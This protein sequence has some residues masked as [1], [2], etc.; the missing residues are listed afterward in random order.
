[1][2]KEF[3]L[4]RRGRFWLAYFLL[5]AFGL[6]A[7][8]QRWRMPDEFTAPPSMA[9]PAKAK[10]PRRAEETKETYAWYE[11]AKTS[12]SEYKW[13]NDRL[14]EI[15]GEADALRELRSFESD[16]NSEK[17]SGAIIQLARLEPGSRDID[18]E[19]IARSKSQPLTTRLA[20]IET[21]GRSTKEDVSDRL[22]RIGQQF[23]ADMPSQVAVIIDRVDS[24]RLLAGVIE[25]LAFRKDGLSAFDE[26]LSPRGPPISC[27]TL[28]TEFERRRVSPLPS[29]A[30]SCFGHPN[31]TVRLALLRWVRE[32]GDEG[33]VGEV[34]KITRGGQGEVFFEAIRTLGALSTNI[35]MARLK[36]LAN[37]Q[38]PRTAGAANAALIR[39]DHAPAMQA[40]LAETRL[41]V[42]RGIAEFLAEPATDAQWSYVEALM[43]DPAPVVQQTLARA[44]SSSWSPNAATRAFLAGL[45]S[46]VPSIRQSYWELLK[47]DH[48]ELP[49]LDPSATVEQQG[50][51]IARIREACQAS[52]SA[53]AK[54]EKMPAV[55]ESSLRDL[56]LTWQATEGASRDLS[57]LKLLSLADQL[58]DALDKLGVEELRSLEPSFWTTIVAVA[59][60]RFEAASGLKSADASERHEAARKLA[61]QYV[62]ATPSLCLLVW[63]DK[64]MEPEE[65]LQVWRQILPIA[66]SASDVASRQVAADIAMNALSIEALDVRLAA[67]SILEKSP[68]RD[69]FAIAVEPLLNSKAQSEVVAATGV[70]RHGE[71][72]PASTREKLS[73]LLSSADATCRTEAAAVLSRSGDAA[74]TQFLI[75]ATISGPEIERRLAIERLGDTGAKT[76]IP[77]LIGLLEASPTLCQAALAALEKLAPEE[78]ISAEEKPF[79]STS[80]QAS[81]WKDWHAT[82]KTYSLQGT[83]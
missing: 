8:C 56:V 47:R 33:S 15:G 11:S 4:D 30:R 35:A 14:E 13:R 53:A 18:L 65:D 6:A 3:Q 57:E 80:E 27:T 63:L 38:N 23:E 60:S 71:Q 21:L 62:R 76:H 5:A 82:H 68:F 72:L 41:Q 44:I 25:A 83:R 51:Q 24:D 34:L 19:R 32:V 42:K 67:C 59:D 28:I 40:A 36:E 48:E 79:M 78:V 69:E 55:S 49:K 64:L 43:L 31:A 37:D 52:P 1:M 9:S 81:R 54:A 16:D 2:E 70:L 12:S 50:A 22:H 77:R 66:K 29:Q 73:V 58:P 26:T 39:Q 74:G 61:A 45:E 20:A 75:Y 10:S 17:S 7:G 46:P